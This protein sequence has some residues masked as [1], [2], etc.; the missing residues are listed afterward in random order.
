MLEF[1]LVI[2]NLLVNTYDSVYLLGL[3]NDRKFIIEELYNDCT[4]AI[5]SI[6]KRNLLSKTDF[7][8][9]CDFCNTVYEISQKGISKKRIMKAEILEDK[10]VDVIDMLEDVYTKRGWKYEWTVR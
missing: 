2:F 4:T 5:K 9:L 7:S 3:N 10:F 6:K 8:V 1:D